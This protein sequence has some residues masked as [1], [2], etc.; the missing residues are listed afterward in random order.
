MSG[1]VCVTQFHQIKIYFMK[2][3]VLL[4]LSCIAITTIY[5]QDEV[6]VKKKYTVSGGVLGA[7]NLSQFR[8]PE[9]AGN[10]VNYGFRPGW[11]AGAWIN[12]PLASAFS[13][14]P[15]LLYSSQNYRLK[16]T[17]ATSPLLMN[18][19]SIKFVS[20]PLFLKFN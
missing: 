7:M 12:L 6:V 4:V 11:A 17:S 20:V 10:E 2:K 18:N 14:E 8:I 9:G 13:I 15:Q 16:S 19:G 1:K 3:L 5:S